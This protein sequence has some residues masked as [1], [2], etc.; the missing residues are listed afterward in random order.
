MKKI[1]V[2]ISLTFFGFAHSQ[3]IKINSKNSLS[4]NGKKVTKYSTPKQIKEIFG[5]PDRISY[6]NNTIWTY[7]KLGYILYIHPK[8][9]RLKTIKVYFKKEKQNFSSKNTFKGELIIYGAK[10]SEYVIFQGLKNIKTDASK[11]DLGD[12]FKMESSNHRLYFFKGR[13][14]KSGLSSCDITLKRK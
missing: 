12:V 14:S 7:D 1:L 13:K 4:V 2:I 3:I 11:E 9:E 6:K 10:I 5:K 8:S